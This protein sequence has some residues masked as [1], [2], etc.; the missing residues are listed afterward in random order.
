ML[1]KYI[2]ARPEDLLEYVNPD[3]LLSS[4]GGDAEFEWDFDAEVQLEKECST[5]K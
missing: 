5:T 1:D 2:V 3:Q 4:I